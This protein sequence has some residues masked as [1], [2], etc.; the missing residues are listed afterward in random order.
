[1]KLTLLLLLS[2][3]HIHL[4]SNIY[5]I[6]QNA[7]LNIKNNTTETIK[8]IRSI[9]WSP[10]LTFS[11]FRDSNDITYLYSKIPPYSIREECT[12]KMHTII[13]VD[14]EV[15]PSVL[16]VFDVTLFKL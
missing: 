16:G 1:M 10:F 11:L 15:P 9:L 4:L 3:V 5:C 14:I 6:I 12:K 8:E 13:H 7:I 2:N